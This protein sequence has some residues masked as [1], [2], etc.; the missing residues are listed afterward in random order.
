M[1][2]KGIRKRIDPRAGKVMIWL[3]FAACAQLNISY[4]L[5]WLEGTGF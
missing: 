2:P 3:L 4:A 1:A 5:E